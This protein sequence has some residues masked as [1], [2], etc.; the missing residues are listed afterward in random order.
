MISSSKSSNGKQENYLESYIESAKVEIETIQREIKEIDL[1]IQQSRNEVEK[2]AQRNATSTVKLQQMSA[3]LE[4]LPRIDIRQAYESA[5]DDQQR[6]FVMRGQLDKLQSDQ[7]LLT[8]YRNSLEAALQF[9]VGMVGSGSVKRGMSAASQTVEMMIQAQESERQ[10][11]ARQ[12]HDGPAQALTNLILQTDIAMRLFD[13]DPSRAKDELESLKV[14][15]NSTFQKVR[16]FITDLRPMMLDDLGLAPTLNRYVETFKEQNSIDVRITTSGLEQRLESYIEVI[17]F[18]AVQELLTNTTRHSS[19]NVVKLQVD[20]AGGEVRLS[21]DDNG[22]GFD[23]NN[24]YDGSG[25][26]LKVI[27]DRVDLLGGEMEIDSVIGQGTRIVFSI[28]IDNKK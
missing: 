26:G 2:L 3:H 20:A 8:R 7:N 6:L 5:L 22:K 11:L 14:S 10:R 28:P 9:L 17:I 4:S 25:M 21:I 13:R 27:R 24:V 16:N 19:A 12:M 15:A 18:R 23:I 1:L